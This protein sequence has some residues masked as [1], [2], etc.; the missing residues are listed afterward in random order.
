MDSSKRKEMKNAYK[1]KK[2][3][4]GICCIYCSGN[5]RRLI[6]ATRDTESLRNRF[7]FSMKTGTNPDPLLLEEWKQYG[8]DSFSFEVLEEIEKREG[9]PEKEFAD[10]IDVLYEMWPEKFRD[11]EA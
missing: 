1:A 3:T 5:N 11:E 9:Q 10:D 8:N 2:I 6:Q 4:A 7:V